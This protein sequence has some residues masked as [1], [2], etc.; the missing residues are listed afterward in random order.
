MASG[1]YARVFIAV[2]EE[3]IEEV[4][5][6]G[7][8]RFETLNIKP[9]RFQRV[10]LEKF[11]NYSLWYYID[12]NNKNAFAKWSMV[13]YELVPYNDE[14]NDEEIFESL[15]VTNGIEDFFETMQDI[16]RTYEDSVPN[17]PEE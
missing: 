11:P 9:N 3:D 1:V 5:A 6:L 4:A 14:P 16:Q 8:E 2:P 15:D 7:A 12:D 17:L 13:S 10:V